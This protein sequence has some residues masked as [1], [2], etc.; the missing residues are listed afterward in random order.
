MSGL[1]QTLKRLW[2]GLRRVDPEAV[3]VTFATGPA[4]LARAMHDQVQRL[5]PDRRHFFVEMQ[6]GGT[7]YLWRRL[8][9]LF[10]GMRIGSGN[11]GPKTFG[12]R[13]HSCAFVVELRNSG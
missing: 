10:G 8:R 3:V 6:S 5:V 12:I 1:R 7:W 2:F 9:R 13:V 4:P 11:P